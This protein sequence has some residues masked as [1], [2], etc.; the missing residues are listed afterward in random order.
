MKR[1][2]KVL[3]I[4]VLALAFVLPASI[5][6][7]A[8]PEVGLSG[9]G[10]TMDGE[11]IYFDGEATVSRLIGAITISDS[12][13]L[14][15]FS[16]ET[17][18][19]SNT[20]SYV[21]T[22]DT[23]TVTENE[24]SKSY[25]V[26]IRG[27]VNKDGRVDSDD[28]AIV[29]NHVNGTSP[30]AEGSLEKRALVTKG[31]LDVTLS[32]DDVV[33]TDDKSFDVK[34]RVTPKNATVSYFE[35]EMDYP[36]F[37]DFEDEYSISS[38]IN[39]W[40]IKIDK[41][42][43][44]RYSY[45]KFSLYKNDFSG[46]EA[47]NDFATLTFVPNS[48][49]TLGEDDDFNIS[50]I[51]GVSN[52]G[53]IL[54]SGGNSTKQVSVGELVPVVPP[55]VKE[56]TSSSITLKDVQPEYYYAI[57]ESAS[58]PA[59][60]S[61]VW[62]IGGTTGELVKTGLKSSTEYFV[63]Y[64]ISRDDDPVKLENSYTTLAG[65]PANGP[66]I[67]SSTSN[68]ITVSFN[69]FVGIYMT[70][71]SGAPGQNAVWLSL[72]KDYALSGT[73]NLTA[74]G[75]VSCTYSIDRTKDTVTFSGLS[76][77]IN[78]IW[79]KT[80][81]GLVCVSPTEWS[82]T[83]VFT[84][85]SVTKGTNSI[86]VPYARIYQY[87]IDGITFELPSSSV[88]FLDSS[89]TISIKQSGNNTVISGLR[90]GVN[91]TL[92]VRVWSGGIRSNVGT[93]KFSLSGS[94]T[95]TSDQPA[96]LTVSATTESSITV[97]FDP[98]VSYQVNST[99][100]DWI[101]S[102]FF[103][104]NYPTS[105]NP[106]RVGNIDYYFDSASN[107]TK[108]TF[109]GLTA[110]TRYTI[111]YKYA[112]KPVGELY[113]K[114]A[115]V[116]TSGAAT[117]K[118]EMP[119]VISTSSTQITLEYDSRLVYRLGTTG[120]WTSGNYTRYPIATG[121]VSTGSYWYYFDDAQNPTEITF[122]GLKANTAYTVCVRYDGAAE[123][124][125]NITTKSITTTVDRGRP[126]FPATTAISGNEVTFV[127]NKELKYRIEGV[128]INVT[129]S[130]YP[131]SAAPATDPSGRYTYYFDKSTNPTTI[132][133][134]NLKPSTRY[135]FWVKYL[136]D[137]SGVNA[138][139][140]NITTSSSTTPVV[141][142]PDITLGG[143]TENSL[144]FK[145]ER[146]TVYKIN[147]SAWTG[148]FTSY[149]T[150]N[151]PVALGSFSY[152]FDSSVAPTQI[153]FK[154]LAPSTSYQI[155]VKVENAEETP[156]TV[157][158]GFYSTKAAPTPVYDKPDAPKLVSIS[159][160]EIQIEF[161]EGVVYRVNDSAWTLTLGRYPI[162]ASPA[163][164]GNIDYYFDDPYMPTTI[165]FSNLTPDTLYT[166]GARKIEADD[167]AGNVAQS[168]F[169]TDSK[170]A[171]EHTTDE[172]TVRAAT[173]TQDGLVEVYCTECGEV[174][175]TR[176]IPKLAHSYEWVTVKE[177]TEDEEGEMQYV[178]KVGGEV[179]ETKKIAKLPKYVK[180]PNGMGNYEVQVIDGSDISATIKKAASDGN[181]NVT[182][183][184]DG[185]RIKLDPSMVLSFAGDGAKLTVKLVNNAADASG[186]LSKAGV[187]VSS[188]SVKVY[189]ITAEKA[190]FTGKG[191][192]TVSLGYTI[193]DGNEATVYFVDSQGN[194][195]KVKSSYSDGTL[196]FETNHFSTYVIEQT[197]KKGTSGVA[198]A[199]IAVL[200][201]IIATGA[202]F[203]YIVYKSKH[204]KA[205]NKFRI[206]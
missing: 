18:I 55:V 130:V 49:A 35:F 196:S 166:I 50:E 198:I 192:A 135:T 157:A 95:S 36:S 141:D 122:G 7:L 178:C 62:E 101:E 145:Y 173:C 11:Y 108:L 134:T 119:D 185:V 84:E 174:L 203:G 110:N 150:E 78:Y 187:D 79:G 200:A 115:A 13:K 74:N 206:S 113:I 109:T 144:W 158:S 97:N 75:T 2:V 65:A 175:E 125:A 194:K 72:D 39:G 14:S 167:V 138:V 5:V 86:T 186:D 133:F 61:T 4:F 117:G 163:K 19:T 56:V 197:A 193:T 181:S 199:I 116:S 189:E 143:T 92:Y 20:G 168:V 128:W 147:S 76:P 118:P 34:L 12:A 139:T 165:T 46:L 63:F 71:A 80:E 100:G 124:A 85:D 121:Y 6:G 30:L 8:A 205:R 9:T 132:T 51:R 146:G 57:W 15:V 44:T 169:K 126:T 22:G 69:G 171:H 91:Y 37:F 59:K 152:Y 29:V 195:T 23:V 1:F 112:D 38:K 87:S 66:S 89:K 64:K 47:A 136:E 183:V 53:E 190:M 17:D 3:T 142:K 160:S 127:Y 99:T 161:V 170:A 140:K 77:A 41:Y 153:T 81:E 98:L 102:S 129:G 70:R 120:E 148:T 52:N 33:L 67:A 107:P 151:T 28:H 111:Y 96:N 123:T 164:L 155:S 24:E 191:K 179:V 94:G 31:V 106:E 105:N 180:E 40:S 177:P 48:S 201:V 68:S 42:V 172:R 204:G 21:K 54:T 159:G 73:Y 103:T 45:L 104:G 149:P 58:A 16:G 182:L 10:V 137:D 26:I 32:C 82:A 25:T 83:P 176:T 88:A 90:S 114:N 93:Y 156:A 188:D 60:T 162:D 184:F 131:T 27:D 202:T 154:G 43:T